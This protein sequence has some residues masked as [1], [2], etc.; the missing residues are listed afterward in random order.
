MY[1]NANNYKIDYIT[2]YLEGHMNNNISLTISQAVN[3]VNNTHF[4]GKCFQF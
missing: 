4:H 3:Q 2:I 1:N